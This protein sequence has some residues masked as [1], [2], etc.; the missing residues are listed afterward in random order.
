LVLATPTGASGTCN[1]GTIT[2]ASGSSTVTLSGGSIAAGASCTVTVNITATA[3][4]VKNNTTGAVSSA[5]GGSGNTASATL[6]VLAP[7]V[8]PP[9]NLFTISHVKSSGNHGVVTFDVTLPGPGV[10][11]VVET[12]WSSTAKAAVYLQPGPHRYALGRLHLTVSHGG[13]IHVRVAPGSTGKRALKLHP[14]G[15]PINLWVTFQPTGGAPRTLAR[16][17]VRLKR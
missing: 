12:A 15:F 16:L 3:A 2:G 10:V 6:T 11:D 9:S 13:V 4:G 1:G 14:R 17:N 8:T 5:E 7:A